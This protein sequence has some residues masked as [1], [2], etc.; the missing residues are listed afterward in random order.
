M[1]YSCHRLGQDM[2]FSYDGSFEVYAAVKADISGWWTKHALDSFLFV[3][4]CKSLMWRAFKWKQ[5]WAHD[6]QHVVYKNSEAPHKI[7]INLLCLMFCILY[8]VRLFLRFIC[9]NKLSSPE[10]GLPQFL[11]RNIINCPQWMQK[12]WHICK[13][14]IICTGAAPW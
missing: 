4:P 11:E 6:E 2:I 1:Y 8:Q 7:Y 10:S 14:S 13:P 9:I 12:T 5:V 3:S